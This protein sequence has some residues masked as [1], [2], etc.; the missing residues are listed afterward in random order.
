M[1]V[2]RT[3]EFD[4]EALRFAFRFTCEACAHFDHRT[5]RCRHDYPSEMHRARFYADREADLLFC[6]EFELE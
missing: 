3:E 2:P 6:K 5:E 1:R 4:E